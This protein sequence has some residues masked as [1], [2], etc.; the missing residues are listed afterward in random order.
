MPWKRPASCKVDA[1]LSLG[2][3]AD[4]RQLGNMGSEASQR[5]SL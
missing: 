4:L 5:P 2:L 3:A 1:N